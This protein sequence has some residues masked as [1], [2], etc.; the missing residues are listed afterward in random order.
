[1]AES[2]IQVIENGRV[3]HLV[4]GMGA[5]NDLLFGPDGML[6]VT[7]TRAEIDFFDPDESD[8]GWIWRIDVRTGAA[9]VVTDEGP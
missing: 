4:T 8:R 1:P 5:P 9:E 7:D 6:W 2:G 3:D